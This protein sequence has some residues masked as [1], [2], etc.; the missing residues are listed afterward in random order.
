MPNL[1]SVI[2][3]TDWY[4]KFLPLLNRIQEESSERKVR[5]IARNAIRSLNLSKACF[6]RGSWSQV[7]FTKEE[8]QLLGDLA[9]ILGFGSKVKELF[10]AT[11]VR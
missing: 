5:A 9:E 1:R 8:S 3:Q 10:Y 2:V 6:G 11:P 4:H 7:V